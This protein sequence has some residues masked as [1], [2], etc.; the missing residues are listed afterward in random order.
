MFEP[1]C[2]IGNRS[3]R[4]TISNQR[5]I[6][7]VVVMLFDLAYVSITALLRSCL[8]RLLQVASSPSFNYL[9]TILG[10]RVFPSC[11]WSLL[12]G[13]VAGNS[14]DV[15]ITILGPIHLPSVMIV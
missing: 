9:L 5:I 11:S 15:S 2:I 8:I 1:L 13:Q 7:V 14:D 10:T 3:D 4:H 12:P 6:P